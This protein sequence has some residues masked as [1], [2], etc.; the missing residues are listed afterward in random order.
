MG[1]RLSAALVAAIV[2][3]PA[4][5][6]A[7]SATDAELAPGGKLRFGLNGANSTIVTRNADG[8]VGGVAPELGR[9]MAPKLGASF[10]P[11]LYATSAAYTDSMEKLAEWDI[12]VTGRNPRAD[13]KFDY[14]PDVIAVEYVLL[15]APGR[16]FADVGEVD[17][18]GVTIAVAR[19][20]SAD[21][22]LSRS[23]KS[24]E[25]LRAAGGVDNVVELLR[26]G[27]A[28]LFATGTGI[29][30]DAAARLPG[31]KII[32]V[33][34]KVSFAVAVPKGRSAAARSRLAALV[35]EA[36]A[37]GVVTRAIEQAGLKGV[38]VP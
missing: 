33:F 17:R 38:H 19:N 30:L 24:A 23:L 9:F 5:A 15:A 32:G 1:T 26:D 20:A 2:V 16:A 6:M 35:N 8:S 13:T 3:M 18:A 4:S 12:C 34:H 21:V 31:S 25:L 28:D 7:Q 11:V 37:A 36:K 10:V 29:A 22:F 14:S 27:K